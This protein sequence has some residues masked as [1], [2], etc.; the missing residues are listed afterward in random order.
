MVQIVSFGWAYDAYMARLNKQ[1]EKLVDEHRAMVVNGKPAICKFSTS[2]GSPGE[3]DAQAGP[4]IDGFYRLE[5]CKLALECMDRQVKLI[6]LNHPPDYI[7]IYII[8]LQ[9]GYRGGTVATSS[10]NSM[11]RLF[12][13]LPGYSGKLKDKGSLRETTKKF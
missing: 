4:K 12:R 1:S 2:V 8:Y 11:M 10:G 3:P 9:C 5:Q 13:Q 6:S 7:Y